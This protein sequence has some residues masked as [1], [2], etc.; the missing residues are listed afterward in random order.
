MEQ[1]ILDLSFLYNVSDNDPVYLYDVINLFLEVVPPG[2]EKLEQLVNKM[3][4]FD[5]IHKQAHFLK[6]S[7]AI[8]KVKDVFDDL[9]KI[10]SLAREHKGKEEIVIRMNNIS[11]NFKEALPLILTEKEKYRQSIS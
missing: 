5:A 6:S 3:D 4:D 7:A 11:A 10:V 2:I 8:I 1:Q 9:V